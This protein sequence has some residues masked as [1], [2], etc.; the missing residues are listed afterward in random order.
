M[1]VLR[2]RGRAASP[3]SPIPNPSPLGKGAFRLGNMR[4]NSYF[5]LTRLNRMAIFLP[6][7]CQNEPN[8]ANPCPSD[9]GYNGRFRLRQTSYRFY[10]RVDRRIFSAWTRAGLYVFKQSHLVSNFHFDLGDCL[11]WL[12]G[13]CNIR[14]LR[15][16]PRHAGSGRQNTEALILKLV[17][18]RE[19]RRRH[20]ARRAARD[21]PQH[22]VAFGPGPAGIAA[23]LPA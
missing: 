11:L 12:S 19:P 16:G 3:R 13:S 8:T 4:I 20:P 9:N 6:Y 10:R 2:Q 5:K 14:N 1:G 18:P 21:F 17:I 22:H 7:H 15:D 23:H